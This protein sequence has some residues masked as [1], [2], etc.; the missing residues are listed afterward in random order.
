[1]PAPIKFK[2][3]YSL[4]SDGILLSKFNKKPTNKIVT[5]TDAI[6]SDIFITPLLI[7]IALTSAC[8]FHQ[9]YRLSP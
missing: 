7:L 6:I 4:L 9:V 8:Y 3:A 5:P 1:M 2:D